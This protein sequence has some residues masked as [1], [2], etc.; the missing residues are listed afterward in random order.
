MEKFDCCICGAEITLRTS[1][2]AE[3]YRS[4]RCCAKCNDEYVIPTR[5]LRYLFEDEE[6]NNDKV[7]ESK[8]K[9]S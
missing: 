1:H 7:Q 9:Q 4:G 6:V 5:M 3:P 8:E 2:N